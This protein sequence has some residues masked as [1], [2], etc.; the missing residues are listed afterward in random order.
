MFKPVKTSRS[1]VENCAD[2]IRQSILSGEVG[3]GDTLPPER[4]LAKMFQLNRLTVRAALSRLAA[5]GLVTVRQGSGYRVEDFR[6]SGGPSLLSGLLNLGQPWPKTLGIIEDLLRVRRHLARAALESIAAQ[7]DF[8]AQPTCDA[9]ETFAQAVESKAELEQIAQA[10]L[11]VIRALV[12]S[13]KSPVY[14]L[15]LNPLATVVF[16]FE[17]LRKA[18]YR[19]PQANVDGY[20]IL[21]YW[22]Q[23]PH[24][25]A[26][27]PLMLELGYRD[28]ATIRC[29][30]TPGQ[31]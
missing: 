5:G 9:I 19:T 17:A 16:Q 30:A 26:V 23:A 24:A 4:Q 3:V 29:L 27:E 25:D 15:C 14:A 10:D 12:S 22:L 20:R 7:P 13:M 6:H 8:D 1:A 21:Q 31:I 2:A 28:Q 11:D 18:I